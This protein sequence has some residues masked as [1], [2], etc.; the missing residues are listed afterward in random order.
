M[1]KFVNNLILE[2]MDDIIST[3]HNSEEYRDYQF[4]ASKLSKNDKANT[5][6]KEVKHLQKQIV[7]KEVMKESIIDLE[8]QMNS[9]LEELN[10]IPLYMEFVEKQQQL[11]C[12]YQNIK[13]R[14]ETYFDN[15][16]N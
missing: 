9:L 3:I 2:K 15:L 12:V 14:L 1:E 5:L 13:T 8:D 16:L 10:R 6:I 4:L 7:K 11:N